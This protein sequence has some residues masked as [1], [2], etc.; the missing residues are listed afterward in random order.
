MLRTML[1]EFGRAF[2]CPGWDFP[3]WRVEAVCRRVGV[4]RK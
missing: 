1:I 4:S 3:W 2:D